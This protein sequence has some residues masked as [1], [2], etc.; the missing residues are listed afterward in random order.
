M[1]EAGMMIIVS[2]AKGRAEGIQDFEEMARVCMDVA[3]NHWMVT[4]ENEQFRGA[5]AAIL[6]LADN[7]YKPRVER[8]IE[9]QKALSAAASGVPVDFGSALESSDIEPVPLMKWWHEIKH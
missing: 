6:T 9:L 4:D 8:T 1:N 7:E 2:E 3:A 5:L